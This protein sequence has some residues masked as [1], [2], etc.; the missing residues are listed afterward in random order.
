MDLE[1][2]LGHPEDEI[3]TFDEAESIARRYWNL[4]DEVHAEVQLAAGDRMAIEAHMSR[5]NDLG[6]AQRTQHRA[7]K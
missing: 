6:F 1:A 5:V 4:W 7:V 3:D 2:M